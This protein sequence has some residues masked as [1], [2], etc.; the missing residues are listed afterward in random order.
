MLCNIYL[1]VYVFL[2]ANLLILKLLTLMC[3]FVSL[4]GHI[5]IADDLLFVVFRRMGTVFQIF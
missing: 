4:V 1:W 2:L 5:R 3:L